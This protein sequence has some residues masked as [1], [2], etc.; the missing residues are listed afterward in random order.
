MSSDKRYYHEVP[1]M[2]DDDLDVYSYRLYGHFKRVIGNNGAYCDESVRELAAACK[3][4][5]GKASQARRDLEER[6]LIR[7][8]VISGPGASVAGSRVT[9]VDVWAENAARYG[10]E[11][12]AP[13][14]SPP[15][16]VVNTPRSPHEHPRSCHEHPCSPGERSLNNLYKQKPAQ[17]PDHHHPD[18]ESPQTAAPV[19]VDDEEKIKAEWRRVFEQIQDWGL[20]PYAQEQLKQRDTQTALALVWLAADRATTNRAGFL[21]TMLQQGQGPPADAVETARIALAA[22]GGSRHE[23]ERHRRLERM[24]EWGVDM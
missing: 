5:V 23:A 6:G 22:Y 13:A 3:M 17:E 16:H 14:P 24:R 9:L 8:E 19:A 10:N 11:V 7:I 4:S 1:N 12:P 21:A 15:V 18:R 2:A 20:L